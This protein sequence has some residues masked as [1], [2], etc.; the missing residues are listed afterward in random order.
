M[1]G[2]LGPRF[3]VE[4][5]FLIL[6]AVGL[7]LADQDWIVIVAV[8]AAGW[9]LV[10]LIELVA[11]QRSSLD[12]IVRQP[13][14]AQEPEPEQPLEVADAPEPTPAPEVPALPPVETLEATGDA[15]EPA[16]AP[17]ALED[18]QEVPPAEPESPPRRRRWFRRQ[19][20]NG[21]EPEIPEPPSHVRRL[22][23]SPEGEP[24]S[25]ESAEGRT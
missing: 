2:R 16:E 15:P 9:A 4:A 17:P 12:W 3:A 25:A 24:A 1:W 23:G 14:S 20:E 11:S 7:G 10:S 19:K 8:M 18:T 5:A 13:G 6:L 21:S 22:D